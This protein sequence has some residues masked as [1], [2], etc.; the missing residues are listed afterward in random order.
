[1]VVLGVDVGIRVLGY[2]LCKLHGLEVSLLK[3]SQIK[4]DPK[5]TLPEKLGYIFQ[6]L[7]GDIS[8]YQPKAIV[9]EKLYSHYR[10]P[11]TLGV[12]AQV[13][14]AVALLAHQ[15]AVD[16]FEYSP[17]R[18]RKS[19]LGKGSADSRQVQRMAENIT[20]RSFISG[21]TADAF[22]LVVAFSHA[23]KLKKVLEGA[24]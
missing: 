6:E 19:F 8:Q 15:R 4:P 24:F 22:S 23:Q 12:L 9:V 17:T 3:E 10:H 13:R 11:T 16:F 14:G 21:H 18:A 5:K 7:S 2:V 1:M 20:G